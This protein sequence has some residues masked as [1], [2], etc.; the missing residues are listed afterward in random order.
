MPADSLTELLEQEYG[1]TP[2]PGY[3]YMRCLW[4]GADG[5]ECHDCVRFCPEGVFRDVKGKKPNYAKCS[6]CGLCAAVCPTLAISPPEIRA[7]E[8]LRA[9]GS[10]EVLSAACTRDAGRFSLRVECLLAL[11]WEQIAVAAIRNAVLLS[12]RPCADCPHPER[13]GKLMETLERVRRFLGEDVFFERVRILEAGEE[14]RSHDDTV[15]RRELF[16]YYKKLDPLRPIGLLPEWDKK[17]N[18]P[19]LF[20]RALLRDQIAEKRAAARGEK[21][22]YVMPLPAFSDACYSCGVCVRRCPDRALSFRRTPDGESFQCVVD[23]WKCTACSRCGVGCH[24]K[25]IS[26]MAEMSLTRLGPASVKRGR[27]YLCV[28]CGKPR[29]PGDADGLCGLCRVRKRTAEYEHSAKKSE[30]KL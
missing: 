29:K 22:R 12:L 15:S 19:P 14:Y 27:A 18:A 10:D 7:R 8:Y 3:N 11:S 17:E 5:R 1:L 4:N 9:L 20:Y 25:A 21:P 23:A 6:R 16:S 30:G 28:V 26:G 2:N 24:E 13:V